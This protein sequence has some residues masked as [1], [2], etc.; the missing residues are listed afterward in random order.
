ME[1]RAILDLL[2][3]R[4]VAAFRADDGPLLKAVGGLPGSA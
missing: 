3:Q 2:R 4:L 1:R